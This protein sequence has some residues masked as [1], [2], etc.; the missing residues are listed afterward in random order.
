MQLIGWKDGKSRILVDVKEIECLR[1]LS[2]LNEEADSI[3]ELHNDHTP[4]SHPG[5][6]MKEMVLATSRPHIQNQLKTAIL[7]AQALALAQHTSTTNI[8]S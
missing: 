8:L 1:I 2:S 6:A 3:Y 4:L 5:S 7:K